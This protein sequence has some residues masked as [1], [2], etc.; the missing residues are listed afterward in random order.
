MGRLMFSCF[1]DHLKWSNWNIY[2]VG[3]QYNTPVSF[4]SLHMRCDVCLEEGEYWKNCLCITVLCTIIMVHK[5]T[6]SSYRLVECIGLWSCLVSS[7]SSKR[8]CVFG[9]HGAVYIKKIFFCLHPSLYLVVSW[10][11]WDWPSVWLTYHQPSVLWQC[12]DS[13]SDRRRRHQAAAAS[14][15]VWSRSQSFACDW[16]DAASHIF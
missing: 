7:L 11:W 1:A 13:G 4:T 2:F 6:S 16:V 12:C 15:L 5:D 8:L 9:L 14:R 3:I 10:T